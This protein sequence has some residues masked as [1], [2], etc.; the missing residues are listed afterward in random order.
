[1][2][3]DEDELALT[4]N[5]KNRKLQLEDFRQ[6]ADSMRLTPVQFERSIKRVTSA[7]R[8]H[9]DDALARSF[10][11]DDFKARLGKLVAEHLNVLSNTP[12]RR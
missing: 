9:L 8:T 11:S 4:V 2:P 7:I 10:L 1:M 12:T 5:G 6:A 3:A